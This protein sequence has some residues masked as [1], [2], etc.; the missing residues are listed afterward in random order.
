MT[1]TFI[2]VDRREGKRRLDADPCRYL[3]MDL[4]HR[5]RRKAADRRTTEGRS[6]CEDKDA[7]MQSALQRWEPSSS[8]KQGKNN[9][10]HN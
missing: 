9:Q 1:Q 3:P 5:K 8:V 6:V 7:Y 4:C 2:F 10:I